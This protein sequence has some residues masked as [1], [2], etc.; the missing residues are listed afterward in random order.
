MG[1]KDLS[2]DDVLQLIEGQLDDESKQKMEEMLK[3]GYTKQ[4]KINH[5]M[6]N[7]KT[8]EEQMRETADKIKALMNDENMSEQNKLEILRNQLSKEDLEQMEEMLRDGGSLEDVM[9]QILKSKSTE[10]LAESEL[11]KIV[12]QMMGDKELSNKEILSLIRDQIDEKA[13]D[14]MENMLKKGFS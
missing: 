4:D 2:E 12:H 10:S 14:E 9:Q 8:K 11:S 13:R 6:K 3:K 5:F 1:G 7:A